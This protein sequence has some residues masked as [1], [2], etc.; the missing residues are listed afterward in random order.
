[1]VKAGPRRWL[2]RLLFVLGGLLLLLGGFVAWVLLFCFAEPPVLAGRPAVLDLAQETTSDG[3]VHLGPSWFQRAEGHSLPHLEGDPLAFGYANAT[4]TSEFLE[5]QE[6]SLIETVE[7]HFPSLL[8]R[9]GIGLAVL[10]N[11]RSLPDYVAPEYQLE[12]LGLS[13]GREQDP[14]PLL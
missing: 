4:L 3:R 1:M 6:R 10:V 12:I 5:L 7:E 2:R 13:R 11:N 9:L 14:Y 8:V